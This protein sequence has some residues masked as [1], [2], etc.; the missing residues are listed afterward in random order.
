MLVNYVYGPT[1]SNCH[2]LDIRRLLQINVGQKKFLKTAVL[3]LSFYILWYWHAI[4]ILC[5]YLQFSGFWEEQSNILKPLMRPGSKSELQPGSL[6]VLRQCQMPD[7]KQS[8][9]EAVCQAATTNQ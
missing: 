8:N 7:E 1:D 5:S 4:P 2:Y 6:N 9:M 3:S